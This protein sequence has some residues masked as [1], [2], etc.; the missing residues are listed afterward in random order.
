MLRRGCRWLLDNDA[1][2]MFA[3]ASDLRLS[4]LRS[5]FLQHHTNMKP[6]ITT[7]G[8]SAQLRYDL[9]HRVQD[10]HIYPVKAPNGSTIVLYAHGTGVGI[11]WR[12][13]RPLKKTAPAPKQAPKKPA[14]KVNGTGHDVVMI[15][16][17]DDDDKPAKSAP[18]PQAEFEDDEEELDPDQPY[19]SIIQHL[20]LAL[21]AEVLHI[22]IPSVPT[23]SAL[24][25]ANTVPAIFSKKIVF[26]VACADLSIRVITLP[27]SP[28]SDASKAAQSQY[29][30]H[31][32]KIPSH[33]G[34]QSI[35]RGVTMTWTSRSEPIADEQS[36]E[37]MEVD[38]QNG[39]TSSGRQQRSSH[40]RPSGASE[41]W[42]L[43]VASHSAEVG[44]LLKI[45]RLNLSETSVSAK[46]PFAAY[47]T[48][49]LRTPA[50]KIAFSSAQYPKRRHS[51]LLITDRSGTARIYDP[52]AIPSRKRR[53]GADPEPGGYVALFRTPFEPVKNNVPT[54]PLLANRKAII[55]AVWAADGTRIMAL[56]AD[57]EWGIWD[58]SR[59]GPNPPSDPSVFSVRGF[60]ETSED[61]SSDSPKRSSRSGLAPMTPNTRKR[62]EVTLFQ[63]TT[64]TPT[65]PTRGGLT[66]AS[67]QSTTGD[68][69]EDSVIIWFGSHAYRIPDLAKFISRTKPTLTPIQGL[70]LLGEAI[71]SID[72]FDT[73]TKDA[74]MA[75][76]RDVLVS[77]DHRL[78]I[79]ANAAQPAERTLNS[80]LESGI[81]DL[82]IRRTDQALLARGELDIGGMSRLLD[83][84]EGGGAGFGSQSMVL[85]NPRR[86]LFASST[87]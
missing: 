72:Q 65:I 9:P 19:P 1:L 85:G 31:V 70:S 15:I 52:F 34:H 58:V 61:S 28:P 45:W 17:S 49:T 27:L 81:E 10:A 20:R 13:G 48:L 43:L 14:P 56:L 11:L 60:V 51:Q 29:G 76:P 77:T 4:E 12:G 75:I 79:L 63:G 30:E 54:P 47:K 68:M 84:M 50:T 62:K 35:P 39:G 40:P 16:D 32:F 42:D 73:T 7:A 26:T 25:Q 82:E 36:D 80:G 21:N 5:S 41:G 86:V 83:N 71:A 53:A 22:A 64:S 2:R 3:R 78:I 8:K 33:A 69:P 59:T 87:S 66:I 6:I 67:L 74:R 46:A 55:G 44:G 37:E 38:G 24:R 57:G 18:P 23:I